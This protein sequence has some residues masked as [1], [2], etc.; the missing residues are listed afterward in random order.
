MLNLSGFAVETV[1]ETVAQYDLA[2]L[3]F[4][5]NEYRGR[6]FF[7]NKKGGYAV[8]CHCTRELVAL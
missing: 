7:E 2:A 8:E 5:L 1:S 3:Y 4:A 6:Q